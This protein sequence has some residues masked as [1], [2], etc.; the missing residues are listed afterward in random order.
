M[1]DPLLEVSI[2]VNSTGGGLMRIDGD[3]APF[4]L[5]AD[6]GAWKRILCVSLILAFVLSLSLANH[7]LAFSTYY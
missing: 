4:Q 7:R 2:S 1:A 5:D 6:A 3:S